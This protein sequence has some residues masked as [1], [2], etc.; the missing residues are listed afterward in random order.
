MLTLSFFIKQKR[1]SDNIFIPTLLI[2]CAF[3]SI[4]RAPRAFSVNLLHIL[5]AVVLY[6]V[7]VE[8]VTDV[9]KISSWFL[10]CLL[11][12]IPFVI[13]QLFGYDPIYV[14]NPQSDWQ[15][16]LLSHSG[17]MGRNYH[18]G[19]L[20]AMCLPLAYYKNKVIGVILTGLLLVQNTFA[21]YLAGTMGLMLYFIKNFRITKQKII[22]G[23]ILL[24]FGVLAVMKYNFNNMLLRF[25][26]WAGLGKDILVNP[27]FGNG[28]GT[29]DQMFLGE[30]LEVWGVKNIIVISSYNEI[31][32]GIAEIGLFPT[33]ICIATL[34]KVTM[35]WYKYAR[36][37]RLAKAIFCGA[38]SIFLIMLFHEV[39]RFTRVIIPFV[40]FCALCEARIKQIK[41]KETEL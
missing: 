28:L 41:P 18:L 32:R 2:C 10:Y 15:I 25:R 40:V 21:G 16:K 34:T 23:L 19:F 31:F 1:Y 7:I 27:F 35:D 36:N 37:D 29:F 6:K 13:C 26:I 8:C 17:M 11:I 3:V 39:I 12:N 30:V 5:F 22:A 14:V 24:P 9:E 33:V 38:V 20:T 4:V